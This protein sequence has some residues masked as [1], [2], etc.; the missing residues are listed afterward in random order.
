MT[1]AVKQIDIPFRDDMVKAALEGRKTCTSRNKNY[2]RP[3]DRFLIAGVE[4]E[5]TNV[6]LQY[7]NTVAEVRFKEEGFDSPAAFIECWKELHP[8]NGWEPH[9]RVWFHE[10]RKV[11]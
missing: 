10:F 4:F 5:L 2:G 11:N 6:T 3:G 8:V 1:S 9:K 7:L